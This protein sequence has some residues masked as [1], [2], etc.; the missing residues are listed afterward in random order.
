MAEPQNLLLEIGAEELP[1][2]AL[3]NMATALGRELSARLTARGLEHGDIQTFAT[4]RRIAVLIA[5]VPDAQ[6]D[7]EMER[8]GPKVSDAF[9][10]D[11]KPTPAAQ[12]FARSCGVPV[13]HLEQVQSDKGAQLAFRSTE[14]GEATASLLPTMVQEAVSRLPVPRRM[15]WS[16]L[17]VEFSRP[18]QWVVLLL[19]TQLVEAHVLGIDSGHITRGHRFHHPEGIRLD[20]ADEYAKSLYGGHVVA[21]FD[22]RMDMIR[23]QVEEAAAALGGTAMMD[24]ELLAETAALVEWPV[25]VTGNFDQSFLRLPDAAIIAPMKGHQ[26]FFP[27]RAAD[28][29]LM[30]HFITIS[31]LDSKNPQSVQSGNERV[32]RPR[33]ADAAFFYDADL[34]LSL[35]ELQQGL[36]AL[37]FQD[38][39]GSIADKTERVSKLAGVVAIAMG[40]NPE[41]V[42]H[43]RRA[44]RLCKCDLLTQ[45]VGEFPE[46]QGIMGREYAIRAGEPNAVSTALN[47]T[48]SSN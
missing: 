3:R 48:E 1:P 28:G 44:G 46:L 41:G 37:V 13:E 2:K 25:A 7:R 27:V 16:D 14:V 24:T 17:E 10:S 36:A 42:K 38:K 8:R 32:L 33:L 39:L 43:A 45:M 34:K 6:T 29:S 26:R 35:D 20:S 5:N 19:G 30:P 15:R 40:E 11:G 12:G 22:V 47:L 4:P 9:D 18:V 31:N 23:T 21:E